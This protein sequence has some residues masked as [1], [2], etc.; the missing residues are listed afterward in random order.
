MPPLS[1]GVHILNS[2]NFSV[3]SV[4]GLLPKDFV[5]SLYDQTSNECPGSKQPRETGFLDALTVEP[6]VDGL[7]DHEHAPLERGPDEDALAAA[8]RVNGLRGAART[9][10]GRGGAG[11]RTDAQ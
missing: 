4:I 10:L 2:E 9:D 8:V 5:S 1:Y 7:T 3:V 11:R 6:L